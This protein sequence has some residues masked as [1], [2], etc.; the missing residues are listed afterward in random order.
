MQ[1]TEHNFDLALRGRVMARG[2][3]TFDQVRRMSNE[4]LMFL[5]YWQ[6]KVEKEKTDYI[7]R[8]IGVSWDLKAFKESIDSTT[9]SSG[10]GQLFIPLSLAVNP[11]LYTYL[12]KQSE[13][14]GSSSTWVGGGEYKPQS[15][16]S[17]KSV[18]EIPKDDFLKMIG[19]AT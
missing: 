10:N 19:A 15:G 6:A 7:E 3:Y 14:E 13:N 1:A 18:S 11:E 12:E 16:E 9:S 5:E 17:I 2:N 4:E 8:M